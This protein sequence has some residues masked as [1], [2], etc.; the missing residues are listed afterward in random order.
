M[1]HT[2]E[3]QIRIEEIGLVDPPLLPLPLVRLPFRQEEFLPRISRL[4]HVPTLPPLHALPITSLLYRLIPI[5][6]L[7]TSQTLPILNLLPYSQ[8]INTAQC[9]PIQMRRITVHISL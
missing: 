6:L 2:V 8:H 7:F 9:I 1:K 5:T 4:R 3:V